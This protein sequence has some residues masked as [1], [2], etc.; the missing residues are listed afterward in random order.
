MRHVQKFGS[1]A[2]DLHD[3][4]PIFYAQLGTGTCHKYCGPWKD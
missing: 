3:L 1:D 2:G 4:K